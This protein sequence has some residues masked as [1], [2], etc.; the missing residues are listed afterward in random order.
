MSSGHASTRASAVAA[1]HPARGFRAAVF[2]SFRPAVGPH[3]RA[4]RFAGV[5]AVGESLSALLEPWPLKIVLDNGIDGHPLPKVLSMFDGLG[6][7][8]IVVVAGI[9]S[10]ILV[11]L[12]RL[13][14]YQVVLRSERTAERI[15]RDLRADLF[16]HLAR[17]PLAFHDEHRSGE[18]TS[19]L[20]T[21][22]NRVLDALIA[23]FT[24][25]AP[26]LFLLVG[27]TAVLFRIDATLTMIGLAGAAPLWIIAAQR[28]RRV[29]AAEAV[30]REANGALTT[31]VADLLRNIRTVQAFGRTGYVEQVFD[32][33]NRAATEG[34]ISS[35]VVQARWTPITDLVLAT[36]GALVL[37]AGAQRVIDQQLS[38][39]TML[40]V[41]SYVGMIYGPVRS[42][43][44]LAATLAKASVSAARL[45]EILEQGTVR[46]TDA[47][48]S[49]AYRATTVTQGLAFDAVSFAYVPGRAALSEVSFTVRLGEMVALVGPS[50]AGKSTVCSLALRLYAP[51]AGRVIIDGTDIAEFAEGDL[52]SAVGYVPQ[53]AWLLDGTIADNI[54]LGHP[55]L[56]RARV[57][58]AGRAC[59]VDPFVLELPDGYD[60]PVGEGGLQLSG[61]ERQRIALARAIVTGAPILLLDEP[62]TGL[63]HDAREQVIDAIERAATNRAV[64]LVTHDLDLA[65]RADRIIELADGHL[66]PAAP[67][68]D[69]DRCQSRHRS[70]ESRGGEQHDDQEVQPQPFA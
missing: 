2:E 35:Y 28:R 64:L 5:L 44:G 62:T 29:R 22:V 61:G 34:N 58:E 26:Q 23:W 50:G 15:G 39:G 14:G 9:A 54:A 38:V 63:D 67:I 17:A 27:M 30:A 21:D 20:T 31:T 16:E 46:A 43:S 70:G 56:S 51:D 42:L 60:S 6:A 66:A 18:L 4:V 52:R 47:A 37:I 65:R 57:L 10:V 49:D 69:H 13:L 45:E 7:T 36:G 59:L 19:R 24:R 11:A 68:A 1:A 3:L 8:G 40:V 12:N 55:E 25:L 53:G 32:R 33:R 48:P 41:L